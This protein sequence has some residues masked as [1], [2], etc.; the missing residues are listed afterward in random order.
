MFVFADRAIG[1]GIYCRYC[2]LQRRILTEL[3]FGGHDAH[4]TTA[5]AD[6]SSQELANLRQV[7]RATIHA[8]PAAARNTSAAVYIETS[9]HHSSCTPNGR[10]NLAGKAI[11]ADS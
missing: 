6:P 10:K 11:S 4:Q 3:V 7:D 9:N 5:T 1:L 2:M 8:L